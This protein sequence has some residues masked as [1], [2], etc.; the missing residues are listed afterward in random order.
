MN[1]NTILGL[2]SSLIGYSMRWL[3]GTNQMQQ[4]YDNYVKRSR[5]QPMKST[6]GRSVLNPK[7]KYVRAAETDLKKSFE[8]YRR[9]QCSQQQR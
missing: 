5:T 7:F 1:L 2:F 3:G 4:S 9:E 8:I 6:N